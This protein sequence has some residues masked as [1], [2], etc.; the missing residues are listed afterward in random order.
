MITSKRVFEFVDAFSVLPKKAFRRENLL[1][2]KIVVW[3]DKHP[4]GT[5]HCFAGWF[6]I[7]SNF[8]DIAGGAFVRGKYKNQRCV[9]FDEGV[10]AIADFFGLESCHPFKKEGSIVGL[11][12]NQGLGG[13]EVWGNNYC[14]DM[15]V[16]DTAYNPRHLDYADSL[17]EILDHWLE[18]GLR[19]YILEL[20]NAD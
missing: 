8:K 14:E 2:E 15:F 3:E 1:M 16:L 11:A 10:K 4:C 13:A 9:I 17:Q 12:I 7:V 20:F 5:A 19:L 18:V 6:V